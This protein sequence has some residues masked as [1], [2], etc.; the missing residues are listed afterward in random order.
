MGTSIHA[1]VEIDY[2]ENDHPFGDSSEIR[3]LATAEL[4]VWNVYRLFDALANAR[5]NVVPNASQL[6]PPCL[7]APRGLPEKV[8]DAVFVRHHLM[9]VDDPLEFVRQ[10][11]AHEAP[12]QVV[13]RRLGDQWVA[14][15]LAR[16]VTPPWRGEENTWITNPDWHSVTWLYRHEVEDA[17]SHAG[18]ELE[19]LKPEIPA[20]LALMRSI[21]DRLGVNHSRWVCW[22]SG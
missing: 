8:S 21:D 11:D 13:L 9:V 19:Q 14:E 20:L 17:L 18:L 1:F 7:Y 12:T 3:S 10:Q 2:A 5:R 4:F 22:F 15:G 16:V 6:S